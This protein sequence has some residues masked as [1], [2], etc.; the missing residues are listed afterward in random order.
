MVK[1]LNEALL[2]LLAS[3]QGLGSGGAK[4]RGQTLAEYGL[5]LT[6]IAV[7]IVVG[8]LILFRGAILDLYDELTF[9][10]Q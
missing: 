3:M 8:A 4:E 2:R 9:C 5:L 10:F 6:L 1:V 7:A